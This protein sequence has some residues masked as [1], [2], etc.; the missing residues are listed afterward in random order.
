MILRKLQ[1]HNNFH[2]K[3]PNISH[4]K[5]NEKYI[6][7]KVYFSLIFFSIIVCYLDD[8]KKPMYKFTVTACSIARIRLLSK[9]IISVW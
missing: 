9:Y 4:V 8:K 1:W 5:T 6:K 7:I 3:I 2:K